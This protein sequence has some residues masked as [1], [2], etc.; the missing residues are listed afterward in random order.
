M[1]TGVDPYEG[2]RVEIVF[3]IG[4]SVVQRYSPTQETI[5][6]F[7]SPIVPAAGVFDCKRVAIGS[8]SVPFVFYVPDAASK[9]VDATRLPVDKIL[10]QSVAPAMTR[11]EA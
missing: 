8:Q 4:A 2:I 7:F 3:E 11:K 5:G 9:H 6:H 1:I 10:A